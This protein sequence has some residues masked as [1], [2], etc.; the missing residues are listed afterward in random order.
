M[1]IYVTLAAYN[2]E[3]NIGDLLKAINA[4]RRS[5]GLDMEVV[6]VDDG[7]TDR[8]AQTVQESPP[9]TKI[10]LVSQANAG[11]LVAL[12]NALK[13]TLALAQEEDICITM[14][15]DNTHSADLIPTM[16]KKIQD[17]HDVVIASRF[18]TG[19]SMVGVPWYRVFLSWGARIVMRLLVRIPQVQDYSISYRAYRLLILK[20]TFAAYPSPLDGRGFAGIAGFLIRLSHMTQR[21]T[22]VPLVLRYDYKQSKSSMR[23]LSSLAGY[24]DIIY[25][26]FRGSY[27]PQ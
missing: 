7:S 19:G 13:K 10:H 16:V 14:D 23:I 15:A 26:H 21:I 11:F 22:E 17:G 27:R 8:T 6:I 3:K 5:H 12:E 2:E 20:K 25:G 9:G 1:K 24:W 18:E 4:V